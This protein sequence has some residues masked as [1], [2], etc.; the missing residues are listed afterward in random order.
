MTC[1]D[2]QSTTKNQKP[3]RRKTS[4]KKATT[5]L[6]GRIR[7]L[8]LAALLTTGLAS[9]AQVIM[10]QGHTDIG[11][12]YDPMADEWELHVHDHDNDIEH[13]PAT[14][15]LLYV[16]NNAHGS[17]P[18]NLPFLGPAGSDVWTL[19]NTQNPNLLFLGF[20]GEEIDSGT[21]V[22][23]Q[24]KIALKAVN[25]PGTFVVYDF[26]TF[27]NPVVWM[28][29]RDG[30]NAADVRTV[31]PGLHQ[32]LN[33]AFSAP[34]DY[35]VWFEAS[36]TN[37][38][39]GFTSSGPVPYVFHVEAM[40]APAATT[41]A[42]NQFLVLNHE[43]TD[44]LCIL[45]DDTAASNQLSLI[46]WQR[47][48]NLD[49]PTNQVI[50]VAKPESKLIL[51][52]G[53]PFGDSG[54]PMWILPQSQNP[55]LLYLGV[56]S[57]RVPSGVFSG[58]LNIRLKRFEGPGYFM[59]WQST[60]PGQYNIRIDTRD[61]ID[62]NDF[63]A[64]LIGS[65]EHFNWGFSAPGVYSATFQVVGL[66]IGDTNPISSAEH[67]FV[68]HVQPLPVPTNY[69]T[70]ARSH[71]PA[72]FNGTATLPTGNADGDAFDNLHE[73]ALGLSAFSSNSIT[74]A[75]IFSFVTTN[76]A[77][78]GALTFTHWVPAADLICEPVAADALNSPNWETLTNIVSSAGS[79]TKETLT[80]RDSV[81][82]TQAA[83]R[84]YQL[85]VQLNSP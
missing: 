49:L 2:S 42:T 28:N 63:F 43:H 22:N 39:N 58:P 48:A 45:Y 21:F 37:V 81:S 30:I 60:G 64:P 76:S 17:V 79:E 82:T 3:I 85:R 46:S 8:G 78:Y 12:A 18:T 1:T 83:H 61:G 40:P 29:S 70:W 6:I 74:E 20:G 35:T 77:Q 16:R 69:L 11:F 47:D 71:W 4:M 15:V 33:F 38:G 13:F 67:T 24:F 59:A 65:H 44:G 31:G 66:R 56:N 53:T 10:S 72:G 5:P 19:P 55:K 36:G 14:D 52:S 62:T 32:D 68:F 73:Y 34:G 26:D 54:Q 9:Q 50:L 23:D 57:E 27:G 84:F 7:Q 51:P 80:I 41:L 25:G 75:P